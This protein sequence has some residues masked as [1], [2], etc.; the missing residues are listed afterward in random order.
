MLIMKIDKGKNLPVTLA[1]LILHL[2]VADK[3]TA[4]QKSPKKMKAQASP[5]PWLSGNNLKSH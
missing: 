3:M 1:V 5:P 2:Q 4:T